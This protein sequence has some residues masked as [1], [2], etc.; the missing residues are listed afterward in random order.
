MIVDVD[1][2]LAIIRRICPVILSTVASPPQGA[3]TSLRQ[4]VGLMMVDQ[5]MAH[6]ATFGFAMATA[7]D[8]ARH[9][10]ATLVTM[11]RVRKAASTE[12]PS[13]LQAILVKLIIIRLTLA[14]E[15]RIIA[16]MKFRS[17]GQVEEIAEAV[18]RVFSEA[19][20]VAAD[21]EEAG[22]YMA[23]IQLH[24]DV[25]KHLA[26]IGRQLPRVIN[27]KY[28]MVM[29]SLRMAQRAYGD[30]LRGDELIAEN[31]VV[32]PAFMPRE[33]KMLAL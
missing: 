32:H 16:F 7:L 8:L 31:N 14:T 15:A 22:P 33:G 2:S 12:A 24:G 3:I 18:G 9:S 10:G 30:P 20:E 23:M 5:N 26:D 21:D 17:R 1:E 19:I 29:P 28:A 4:C 6:P 13:S 27:Y 11:D 25:I